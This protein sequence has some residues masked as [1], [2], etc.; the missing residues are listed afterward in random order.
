MIE[1]TQAEL[2]EM[3]RIAEKLRDDAA[4][5]DRYACNTLQTVIRTWKNHSD[6]V[7]QAAISC[8]EYESCTA[9]DLSGLRD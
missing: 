2:S 1:K 7:Q 8:V 5:A 6:D 4:K 3:M 9:S